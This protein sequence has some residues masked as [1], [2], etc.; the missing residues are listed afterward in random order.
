MTHFAT[1]LNSLAS[2]THYGY[3]TP[4]H[5]PFWRGIAAAAIAFFISTSLAADNLNRVEIFPFGKS[6][7]G[8]E[9]KLVTLRNSKGMR[10]QV[11][12]YGA[13]I[14]EILAPDHNG[15]FTNVV[16]STDSM[17]KY[18]RFPR[19]CLLSK[20]VSLKSALPRRRQLRSAA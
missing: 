13:I 15:N 6:S 1:H 3:P 14:K 11:I 9:V 8:A 5:I 4:M 20:A 18:E 7:D 12:T 16:L 17:E 10:V 19:I 2:A